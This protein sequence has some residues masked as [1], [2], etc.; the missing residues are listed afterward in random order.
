MWSHTW[1][2]KKKYGHSLDNYYIKRKKSARSGH[3]LNNNEM[4]K[5]ANLD[6]NQA[7]RD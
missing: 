3:T 1:K 5:M 4:E 2:R 6:S 7:V